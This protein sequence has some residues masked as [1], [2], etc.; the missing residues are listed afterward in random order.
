[1]ESK[2]IKRGSVW[3]INLGEVETKSGSKQMGIRPCVIA[4]NNRANTYGNVLTVIPVSSAS[5]KIKKLLP[6]HTILTPDMCGIK[7]NSVAMAEQI[8]IVSKDQLIEK[9]FDLS[10]ELVRKIDYTILIQLGLTQQLQRVIA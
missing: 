3:L 8:T 5:T 1:M 10:D 6:T 2:D 7:M 9:L 4:S